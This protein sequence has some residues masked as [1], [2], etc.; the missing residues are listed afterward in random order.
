MSVRLCRSLAHHRSLTAL[1][2]AALT[3]PAAFLA[4]RVTFS[5]KMS[6][7]YPGQHPHVRLYQEFTEMLKMTNT[8]VVTVSVRDGTIYQKLGNRFIDEHVRRLRGR[9]GVA[10]QRD[11]ALGGNIRMADAEQIEG[12]HRSKSSG[13]SSGSF[14]AASAWQTINPRRRA[15]FF[16]RPGG[17]T[18]LPHCR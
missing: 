3:L 4:R 17:A 12:R 14:M 1:L 18:M 9:A 13:K 16:A 15:C 7:Y 5:A 10:Q 8:V 2:I 11:K 6:D